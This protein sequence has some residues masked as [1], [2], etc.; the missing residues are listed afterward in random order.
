MLIF[1]K[2]LKE[3]AS[4]L[5]GRTLVAGPTQA[6]ILE[7][8][9]FP[10]KQNDT[11]NYQPMLTMRPGEVFTPL[12]RGVAILP[13]IVCNDA[14]G[15]TG[16]C[17]LIQSIEVAGSMISKPGA[18]SK[19]LGIT[20]PKDPG[21]IEEHA[22]GSLELVMARLGPAVMPSKPAKKR[23]GNGIADRR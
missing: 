19:A 23:I 22:D 16:A 13:L 14:D 15:Q 10:R 1:Q 18:V 20:V 17:V 7:T 11:P 21:R 9:T 5:I 6:V 2:K 8:R 12:H 3:F 4:E